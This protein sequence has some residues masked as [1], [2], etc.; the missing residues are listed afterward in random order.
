[1]NIPKG[2]THVSNNNVYYRKT[3]KGRLMVWSSRLG[4]WTGPFLLRDGMVISE[5]KMG[6]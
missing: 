1:M 6:D 4:K 2:A 5:L 3:L